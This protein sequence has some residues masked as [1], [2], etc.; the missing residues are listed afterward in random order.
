L[1]SSFFLPKEDQKGQTPEI[2]SEVKISGE[3][4][5]AEKLLEAVYPAINTT[6]PDDPMVKPEMGIVN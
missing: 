3:D 6:L 4:S 1:F 2:I 5:W